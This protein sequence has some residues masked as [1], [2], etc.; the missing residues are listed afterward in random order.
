MLMTGSTE[1]CKIEK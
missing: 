1:H